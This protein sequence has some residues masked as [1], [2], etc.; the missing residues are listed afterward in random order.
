MHVLQRKHLNPASNKVMSIRHRYPQIMEYTKA[1]SA[2]A[3]PLLNGRVMSLALVVIG[4]VLLGYVAGE[5][6]GMYRSQK[7]LEAEWQRQAATV[8]VPGKAPVSPDQLLTRLEIP[9]IQMDAIVVEGAS[10]RELSEGPGHMK[11]TA[12][13][14]ETGNAVIT[15]HRD[16][17][18]R[19]IY[20]LNRGDQIKVRRSGRLFT[21]EVTGKKIVMPEDISVIK[22]TNDPQLTL[23]TCYP[24]YY[25][26]PAPKRLV[27][28]SKLIDSDGQAAQAHSSSQ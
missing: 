21:Y 20:E 9:K 10:R 22:P 5:Y 4:V 11:Q 23:I 8:S 13:P 16:T 24:T 19:H 7:N 3:R 25:I 12:Q 15:A 26:G 28:F 1:L 6:W 18:F 14:G 27:V 2:K 17:F